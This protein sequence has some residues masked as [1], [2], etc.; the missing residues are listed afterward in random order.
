[1]PNDEKHREEHFFFQKVCKALSELYIDSLS[2][3][4]NSPFS[5]KLTPIPFNNLAIK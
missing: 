3:Y 5:N 1:M 4:I 2:N